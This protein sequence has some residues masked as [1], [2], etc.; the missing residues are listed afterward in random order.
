MEKK[1]SSAIIETLTKEGVIA[2]ALSEE[3]TAS[4]ASKIEQAVNPL[5]VPIVSEA[6]N[7]ALVSGKGQVT[8]EVSKSLTEQYKA[9]NPNATDNELAKFKDGKIVNAIPLFVQMVRAAGV[10]D[11]EQIK[12]TAEGNAKAIYEQ[13][14]SELQEE[15]QRYKAKIQQADFDAR[16]EAVI[17]G[18]PIDKSNPELYN[19]A[20]KD[21]AARLSSY[22]TQKEQNGDVYLT[23]GGKIVT[24]S[25]GKGIKQYDFARQY[26]G[27]LGLLQKSDPATTIRTQVPTGGNNSQNTLLG[28]GIK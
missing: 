11:A 5:I 17:G 27:G 28:L 2:S 1:I 3:D 12:T 20:K 4:L 15:L 13:R 21:F 24:D 19:V 9:I 26:F 25:S 10:A 18:L 7:E 8:A 16:V 14:M 22:G 6:K 23:E